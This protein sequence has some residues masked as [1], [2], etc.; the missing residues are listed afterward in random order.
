MAHS[1]AQR[2]PTIITAWLERIQAA[3]ARV[4]ARARLGPPIALARVEAFEARCGVTLPAGYRRFV[5]EIGNGGTGL[6]LHGWRAFDPDA[7][8]LQRPERWAGPFVHPREAAVREP[9]H[10]DVF[11]EPD[12]EARAHAVRACSERGYLPLGDHGCGV[13]TFLVISGEEKGNVWLSD[14]RCRKLPLP[15]AHQQPQAEG[16]EARERW[17][18][19]LLAPEN[20]H[21]IG[22]LEHYWAW[23]EGLLG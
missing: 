22:F 15:A 2:D 21:R 23:V 5:T 13:F 19:A 20:R 3:R 9:V 18:A 16:H 14:D 4:G 7:P 8:S 6:G 12:E 11:G 17:A 1:A 10:R